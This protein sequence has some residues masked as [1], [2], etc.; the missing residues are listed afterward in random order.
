M[1]G[2]LL[3]ASQLFYIPSLFLLLCLLLKSRFPL[4]PLESKVLSITVV[5]DCQK[6]NIAG[7]VDRYMYVGFVVRE[8]PI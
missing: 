7:T 8:M 3:F 5:T 6:T 2:S 4:R 1:R